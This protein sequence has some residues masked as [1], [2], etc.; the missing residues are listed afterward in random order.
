[1]RRRQ[2]DPDW[3]EK[4]YAVSERY[5]PVITGLVVLLTIVCLVLFIQVA[6]LQN[7][8]AEQQEQLENL[9]GVDEEVT[10]LQETTT[11]LQESMGFLA[12]R[13]NELESDVEDVR[14]GQ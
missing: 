13:M 1:M 10:D 4:L 3:L 8:V 5:Q 14:Q 9:D 7:T 2:R 11:S 6:T 12:D